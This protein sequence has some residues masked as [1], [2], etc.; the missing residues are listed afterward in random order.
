MRRISTTYAIM[1]V[2]M[3]KKNWITGCGIPLFFSLNADS[4][5]ADGGISGVVFMLHKIDPIEQAAPKKKEAKTQVGS[6]PVL[7]I[8]IMGKINKET[9][10]SVCPKPVKKL[11]AWKPVGC[12]VE[13]SLSAIKAR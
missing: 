6:F 3:D 7:P 8:K 12:C 9:L 11:C 4:S 2:R 1:V 10:A 13:S 5:F